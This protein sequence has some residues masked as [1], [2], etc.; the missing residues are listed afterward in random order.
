MPIDIT[1]AALSCGSAEPPAVAGAGTVDLVQTCST[2]VIQL[3]EDTC[4]GAR[5]VQPNGC[6][7]RDRATVRTMSAAR[8]CNGP[9]HVGGHTGP[10][11]PRSPILCSYQRPSEECRT[12]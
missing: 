12:R 2:A 10:W 4:V 9:H 11:F 5:S 7:R 8:L 3:D 6:A 1:R